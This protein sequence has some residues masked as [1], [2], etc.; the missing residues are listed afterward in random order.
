M[1]GQATTAR[2]DFGVHTVILTL[3]WVH[4]SSPS[5]QIQIHHLSTL[6]SYS[7]SVGFMV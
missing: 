1:Q 6:F 2:M 5:D 4:I 3:T 7:V